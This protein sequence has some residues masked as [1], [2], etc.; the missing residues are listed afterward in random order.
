MISDVRNELKSILVSPAAAAAAAAAA[1][2]AASAPSFLHS[3]TAPGKEEKDSFF[4]SRNAK[5]VGEERSGVEG[6]VTVGERRDEGERVVEL[7]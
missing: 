7:L 5:C 6:G 1:Y 3:V 4:F 2:P